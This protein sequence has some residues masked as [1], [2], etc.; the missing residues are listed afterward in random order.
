MKKYFALLLCIGFLLQ[1]VDAANPVGTSKARSAAASFLMSHGI[2]AP[3]HDDT[4]KEW[5]NRLYL[6][7]AEGGGFVIVP[8]TDA[9]Q[10]V[11]AYSLAGTFLPDSLPSHVGSLIGQYLT[12]ISSIPDNA[13][14]HPDWDK[15][16]RK[17]NAG[18][19]PLVTAQW[20]QRY[21]YNELT[22]QNMQ[23]DPPLHCVT[24]CVAVAM[25]Q[26]MH[27]WHW[28]DTGWGYH[29]YECW[30][31][32]D[33]ENIVTLAEQFDTVHYAWDLMPDSLTAV[34]SQEEIQ[35]VAKLMYDC[36]VSVDMFYGAFESGASLSQPRSTY[37]SSSELALM[38]Y[39]KYRP[40]LHYEHSIVYSE[41]EWLAMIKAELDNGR[42]ILYDVTSYQTDTTIYG[43]HAIV[44]DGYDNE[45]RLH[46]NWGWYGQ[47]DGYYALGNFNAHNWAFNFEH[48]ALIGIEPSITMPDTISIHASTNDT[49][50]GTIVGNGTYAYADTVALMAT[51]RPGY[52]FDHWKHGGKYNPMHMLATED[53]TDTAVIVPIA[54]DTIQYFNQGFSTEW[55]ISSQSFIRNL[56]QWGIRIPASS[57]L[58]D[59]KLDAVEFFHNYPPI[60]DLDLNIYIGESPDSWQLV[61]TQHFEQSGLEYGYGWS[62]ISL[63]SSLAIDTLGDLWII[64]CVDSG[65]YYPLTIARSNYCGNSDGCWYLSDGRWTT[66][67]S[68]NIMAT[69]MIRAIT[70]KEDPP[71]GIR[72]PLAEGIVSTVNGLTVGITIPQHADRIA[73]YDIAGRCIAE[74]IHTSQASL[75]VPQTGAYVIHATGYV[76]KKIIILKQ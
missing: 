58:P 41:S 2:A 57:L 9:V 67:D 43:C 60:Q 71:M 72:Q 27:Y 40:T 17:D 30:M 28:P 39:F 64:L 54:A 37:A 56:T 45:M 44:V 53:F 38:T 29:E 74:A 13:K 11:L 34:S 47:Y 8:A 48:R 12:M 61:R 76:P 51:A 21:P 10:P 24:G 33:F 62:S 70:H 25:A 19:E 22:P 63:D 26:L 6:F 66:A 14:V 31:D 23:W 55:P 18:V 15:P 4:P 35:A 36:G 49:I 69:W 16:M 68:L 5:A 59:H 73:I 52:R 20:G 50:A 46:V 7:N 75:R 32:G 1:I 3:L 42:P 65:E